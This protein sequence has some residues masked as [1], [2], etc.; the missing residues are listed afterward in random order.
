[1]RII[2]AAERLY[3][4]RGIDRVSLREIGEWAGQRNTAAIQ[5]HFGGRDGLLT[6]VFDHGSEP[7]NESRV[8]LLGTFGASPTLRELARAVVVPFADT[9]AHRREASYYV[10]FL[11]RLITDRRL[12]ALVAAG[13]TESRPSF[14]TLNQLLRRRLTHLPP[15]VQQ[16][17]L[18]LATE[19]TIFAL[20]A[21]QG[22]LPG[23]SLLRVAFDPFVE[24][25]VEM[26]QGMLAAPA[27]RP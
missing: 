3:A 17:R 23:E 25:L 5:Y 26:V 18:S 1:M 16:A 20:A 8:R 7:V 15:K 9:M 21:H 19:F 14:R 27:A 13:V 2:E 24:D 6:A 12:H 10:A 11:A 22:A 4:E